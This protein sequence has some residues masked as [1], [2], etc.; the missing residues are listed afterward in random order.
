VFDSLVQRDAPDAARGRAFARF[1]TRFQLV[2]VVG[3][4]V[5]VA[6]HWKERGGLFLLAVVLLFA[7]LSYLG[8][9]R[10]TPMLADG[11][12]LDVEATTESARRV[13][14]RHL[15]AR[16]RARKPRSAPTGSDEPPEAFPA[17]S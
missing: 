1:E 5:A 2:W 11:E 7:G 8:T 16:V 15:R 14:R 9:A 12:A 4:V 13:V 17:G 3:A 10:R 6:Y